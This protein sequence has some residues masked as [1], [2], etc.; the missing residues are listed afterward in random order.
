MKKVFSL[1]LAVAVGL[2]LIPSF[3][4]SAT[5]V[6]TTVDLTPQQTLALY[7]T[8][9]PATFYNGSTWQQCEFSYYGSSD[10]FEGLPS[11]VKIPVSNYDIRSYPEGF[12]SV[13]A[14]Y[15]GFIQGVDRLYYVCPVSSVSSGGTGYMRFSL[16]PSIDISGIAYYRQNVSVSRNWCGYNSIN[17]IPYISNA[18]VSS[19]FSYSNSPVIS[20]ASGSSSYADNYYSSYIPG[21][22]TLIYF[23][24]LDVY[25]NH[26]ENGDDQI[27][28]VSEQ[29]FNLELV[30]PYQLSPDSAYPD[31]LS[32]HLPQY[33]NT[34]YYV[35]SIS[36]PR[37]SDGY[38]LPQPEQ[39]ENPDY[40]GVLEDIHTGVGMS[41]TL[42]QQ[43]LAKLDAIYAKMNGQGISVSGTVEIGGPSITNI[44]VAIG[45]SVG[46]AVQGL[47]VPTQADILNFRLG[48]STLVSDTF[49]PFADA[50]TARDLAVNRILSA[51]PIAYVDLPLLDLRSSG[52]DFYIPPETFTNQGFT[53][54]DNKVKVPLKPREN[55]WGTFYELLKWAIDIVCTIAFVNMLLNKF[56]GLIVGKKV[57][58]IEDDN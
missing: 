22:N 7:G 56:T 55:E 2:F 41:N 11:G 42:L 21:S 18:Y 5:V 48:M 19:D 1:F 31:F 50:Q 26:V 54:Q 27:F 40:S 38:I 46:S 6:L 53:V 13:S 33:F 44:G 34:D 15:D 29:I 24:Y 25:G 58:E 10:S 32:E 14:Y 16:T 36:C 35:I 23:Y 28:S 4:A 3:D 51:S 30:Y 12:S 47:F 45:N 52:V 57:V 9:I 20:Y 8:T 17:D 49:A 37:V 43:I 39:P